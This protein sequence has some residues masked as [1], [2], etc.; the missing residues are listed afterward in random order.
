[1]KCEKAP[2][3]DNITTKDLVASTQ[4]IGLKIIH[5][6]CQK[7]WEKEVPSE[8]KKSV[9][10]PTHKKQDKLDCT[11]YRGISLLCHIAKVFSSIILQ[12]IR[13]R[14]DEILS[15]TKAGFRPG[16]S[17]IDQIF[18][19]RQLAEKYKEF[20]KELYV[21]YI[22]F[23]KAFDSVMEERTVESDEALWVP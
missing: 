4:R 19:L 1:M 17:A 15:E 11:N 9:I 16:R 7:A 8:W 5:M 21:C 20:G 22:D 6:L 23:N 2:G 13:Q 10:V 3:I 14:T 18:T 12:R